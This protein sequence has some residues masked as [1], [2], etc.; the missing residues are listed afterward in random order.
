M[1]IISDE[2]FEKTQK[3]KQSRV[4]KNKKC[5]E[6]NKDFFKYQTKGELLFTGY[7]RCG[8]CGRLLR[9]TVTKRI[10]KNEDGTDKYTKYYYYACMKNYCK[11]DCKCKQK[12]HKNNTIEKP[13]LNEIYKYFDL[14]EQ[15]DLS[16]YVRKIHKNNEETDE[17]E[18]KELNIELK[19]LLKKNELLKEEV[20]KVIMGQSAFSK[21]LLT[22]MMNENN[23]KIEKYTNRK[24]E[25]EKINEQKNIEFEQ[26]IALKNLIPDWKKVFENATIEQK[27]MLLSSIIKEI[28]VYDEKI[29]VKLKISFNEF[30][31]TA[32]KL[33][34]ENL[35]F[36]ENITNRGATFIDS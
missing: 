25:L 15:R 5:E 10:Q 23:G 26:M 21:D 8:G 36:F 35:F 19:E 30:I 24:Y 31:S 9:S 33:N 34:K 4:E 27:K 18:L 16:D 7:I 29:D 1:Q 12:S 20:M 2:Q 28:V 17:K 32:K 11:E 6:D 14:L 22:E 3:I 13:V